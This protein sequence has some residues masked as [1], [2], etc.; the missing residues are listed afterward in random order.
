MK[1]FN[2]IIADTLFS[3]LPHNATWS[4]PPALVDLVV[5]LAVQDPQNGQEQVDN[6]Q[7]QRDGGSNLLLDMVMTH[8]ELSV[9]EDV[10]REDESGNGP[11]DKLHCAVHWEKSSHEAE[12]NEQPQSTEQVWHPVG[13]VIFRLAG[14]KR[15]S[16][17]DAECDD[18]GLD[19]DARIVERG[20]NADRVGFQSGK[21]RQEE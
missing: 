2:I 21:S 1:P 13:E 4:A 6:V 11:V 15:E 18:E 19:D 5:V 20:H 9:H 12:N 3:V 10:T 16:D 17:E 14:K 8:D 7:V